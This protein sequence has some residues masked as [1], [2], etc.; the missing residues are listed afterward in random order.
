MVTVADASV[1]W[2][3]TLLAGGPS[4][5]ESLREAWPALLTGRPGQGSQSSQAGMLAAVASI[6]AGLERVTCGQEVAPM[7]L[8]HY[9]LCLR[10]FII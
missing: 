4:P 5:P 7:C 2:L 3:D 6:S 8:L 1:E 9:F 10:C